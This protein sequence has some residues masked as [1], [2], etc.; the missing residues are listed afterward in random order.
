LIL[1]EEIIK[2]TKILE[3]FSGSS[4]ASKIL[5]PNTSINYLEKKKEKMQQSTHTEKKE[6]WENAVL[7]PVVCLFREGKG[8]SKHK[9]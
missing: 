2:F 4:E 6:R 8:V 9:H 1:L 7:F 3:Q 5:M